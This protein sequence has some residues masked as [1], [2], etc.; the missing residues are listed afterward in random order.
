M[1]T[2]RFGEMTDINGSCLQVESCAGLADGMKRVGEIACLSRGQIQDVGGMWWPKAKADG[3]L[4]YRLSGP[5]SLASNLRV[6][7]YLVGLE[8]SLA[9]LKS[10]ENRLQSSLFKTRLL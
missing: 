3:P 1:L 2:V 6:I 5:P 8:F 10:S 7:G 9:P 4:S